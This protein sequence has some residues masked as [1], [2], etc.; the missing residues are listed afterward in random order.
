MELPCHLFLMLFKLILLLF[1]FGLELEHFLLDVFVFDPLVL[2]LVAHELHLR[3]QLVAVQLLPD[4]C[5]SHIFRLF[6]YGQLI[7]SLQHGRP[8]VVNLLPVSDG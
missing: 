8:L 6:L 5:L 4:L 1:L 2:L 3:V 7:L